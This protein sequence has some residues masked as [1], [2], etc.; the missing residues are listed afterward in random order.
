MMPGSIYWFTALACMSAVSYAAQNAEPQACSEAT[1]VS[2]VCAISPH[3]VHP[4]QFALGFRDVIKKRTKIA[5]IKHSPVDLSA[6]LEQNKLRAVKGPRGVFYI[7]DGHHRCRA[8]TEEDIPKVHL[9]ISADF[10]GDSPE[11][12]WRHMGRKNLVWRYD[13]QG[14]GPLDPALIPHSIL[15]LRNDAYRDLAEDALNHGAYQKTEIPFQEF[16]WANF[17]RTRIDQSLVE[18][19]YEAAV[20]RA[21]AISHDPDAQHLPGFYGDTR[22]IRRCFDPQCQRLNQFFRENFAHPLL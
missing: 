10:S 5:A 20:E 22:L 6:Y 2:G 4:T 7:I 1:P 11:D 3:E 19:H 8:L 15:E 17:Y 13:E 18:S 16:M 12:F 14:Q 21:V 9:K